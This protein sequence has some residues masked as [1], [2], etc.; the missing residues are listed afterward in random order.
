[1]G[2]TH[3]VFYSNSNL[4]SVHPKLCLLMGNNF[5]DFKLW[6]TYAIPAQG[7]TAV[8]TPFSYS[9]PVREFY[10]QSIDFGSGANPKFDVSNLQ[11]IT[12]SP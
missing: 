8:N 2:E 10:L 12:L 1:M 6:Q 5:T 11:S 9:G 3:W 4:P 7:W